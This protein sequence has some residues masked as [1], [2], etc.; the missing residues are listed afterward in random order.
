MNLWNQDAVSTNVARTAGIPVLTYGECLL[1]SGP[2]HVLMM[3]PLP[4]M[5]P[6]NLELEEGEVVAVDKPNNNSLDPKPFLFQNQAI[7]QR[8]QLAT[9]TSPWRMP[10]I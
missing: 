8:N 6:L 10:W 2:E 7:F 1:K 9:K 5:V 4:M 3:Q